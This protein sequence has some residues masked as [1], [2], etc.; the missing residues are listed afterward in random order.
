[1]ALRQSWD[2]L[3]RLTADWEARLAAENLAPIGDSAGTHVSPAA[4]DR[5][6]ASVWGLAAAVDQL[7]GALQRYPFESVIDQQVCEMLSR[8]V[9]WHRIAKTLRCSKRRVSR[10]SFAIGAWLDPADRAA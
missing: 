5:A 8:R 7:L 4:A 2:D 9:P 1:V 3:E 10:V 6:Q